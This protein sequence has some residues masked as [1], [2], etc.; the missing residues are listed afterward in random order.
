VCDGREVVVAGIMEHIEEAGIHSGDSAC[1]IPPF[2]LREDQIAAIKDYTIRMARALKVKGLMN[3]QYAVKA[4]RVY[5]L[6][7]NPR[8]SRTVPFVSK[9][10]G[11][12]WAKA[13]ARVMAGR[14]LRSLGLSP[15]KD[16][17]RTKH[18]SVKEAVFPFNKFPGADTVLGPEMKSTG[19]VMGLDADFGLAFA[20][21][22]LA[23]NL[24]FPLKG[25]VFFSV[26]NKDKRQ[27]CL[28]AGE[29]ERLGFS[30]C[31]TRGTAHALRTRGIKVETVNKVHESRP[32][33]VDLINAR[34]IDLI[35]NTPAGKGALS[36]DFHIRRA[37]LLNGVSC[38][39]TLSAASETVHGI[40]SM[41]KAGMRVR[42]LQDYHRAP[43]GLR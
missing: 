19:E 27:G 5:V 6:E 7:V 28:V 4:E 43:R 17:W 20:K 26:K 11:V 40:A 9:A 41:Q 37:A 10:T 1:V 32:N 14:S 30:I 18:H 35:I 2:T 39:T 22:Q 31:A 3:V 33:I 23:A 42:A 13:A 29:L 12:A 24:K 34:D 38:V 25:R 15:A 16:Y 8:A 21:S 36:D